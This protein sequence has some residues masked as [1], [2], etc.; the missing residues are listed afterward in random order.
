M[1]ARKPARYDRRLV[2]KGLGAGLGFL[3]LLDARGSYAQPAA[4]PKRLM[5]LVQTNGASTTGWWPDGDANLATKTLPAATAPLMDFR[6][7][8]NIIDGIE[9]K[10]FTDY[11]NHGAGHENFSV[12]LTGAKGKEIEDGGARFLAGSPS[13][14]Q[15]VADEIAKKTQLPIRALTLGCNIEG[16]YWH[17]SRCFY[18]G[19][20][21]P[22]TPENDPAK[23][24]SA[25]FT[26]RTMPNGAVDP[27]VERLLAKRKSTLDFLGRD[28]EAF[29]KRLGTEDRRKVEGH[30]AA[31]R[32]LEKGLGSLGK[33]AT[34]C[35]TIAAPAAAALTNARY[36]EI[37]NT[38]LDVA[39]AA[40][41][42]D[43]TRVVGVQLTN[44]NG[45]AL[46]FSWLGLEGKGMEFSV[47]NYHD[48]SHRPG[49]NDVD[50]IKSEAWFMQQLAGL[51]KRLKSIPEGNGT[52]LD[53]TVVLW[54]NHMGNGGAHNSNRLP[55]I[56]AGGKNGG[57][58][59]GQYL[60]VNR[61]PTNAVYVAV[62]QAMGLPVETFGDPKYGG[63]LPG[64]LG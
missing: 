23:A 25:V 34:G 3:P 32:E 5:V 62:C 17:Q 31:V 55:F 56:V 58:K 15:Y 61:Q 37:L 46:T 21:L 2:L 30:L 7:D 18:R 54:I 4:Y 45:G 33:L 9:L 44:G 42:C 38:H 49:P 13:L 26:G 41:K 59:T 19:S 20:D 28:L 48:V 52:M 12:I 8:V 35:T 63:A 11:P 60:K 16:R 50:K 51:L 24:F 39:V 10:N 29:G 22:V 36:P 47:R 53:N 14:D 43:V 6:S 27:A 64:L 1:N 57:M 40:L